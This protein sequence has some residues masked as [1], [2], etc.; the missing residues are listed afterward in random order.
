M[1]ISLNVAYKILQK[2]LELNYVRYW[3]YNSVIAQPLF[4]IFFFKIPR[5][6]GSNIP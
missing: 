4:R 5:P 2:L 1:P 3:H 6:G